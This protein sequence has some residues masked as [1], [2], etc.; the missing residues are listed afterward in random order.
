MKNALDF[1]ST[2]GVSWQSED[3]SPLHLNNPRHFIAPDIDPAFSS[4]YLVEDM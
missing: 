1:L 4:K 3:A 2:F